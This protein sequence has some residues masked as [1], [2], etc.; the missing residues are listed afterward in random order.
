MLEEIIESVG[1]SGK[2]QWMTVMLI[3]SCKSVMSLSMLMMAY[4]GLVPDWWCY[5][6]DEKS[7]SVAP[8]NSS[9]HYYQVCNETSVC[10]RN[11]EADTKTVVSKFDLVC[12]NTWIKPTVTAVQMG[13]VLVGALIGGQSGDVFGRKKTIYTAIL[14]HS[15]FNII[16]AFSVNWQMFAAFRFLI[17]GCIGTFLVSVVYPLEFIGRKHRAVVSAIPFWT[18]GLILLALASYLIRDWKILHIGL[19]VVSSPYLLGWFVVPESLRWLSTKDRIE[20]AKEILDKIARFNGTKVPENAEDVLRKVAEME[21]KKNRT[22][23][24]YTYLDIYKGFPMLKKSLCIQLIWFSCST[25]S[26]GLSFGIST[27]SGNFYLNFF[28]MSVTELTTYFPTIYCLE[29]IGRRY[30]CAG[31]LFLAAASCITALIIQAVND[32]SK[33][34][35]ITGVSLLAKI[36][37]GS[38]WASLVVLSN[39]SYPTV[40]RSLG[41]G[42]ANTMAR[43]GGILAPFIF[44]LGSNRMIPYIIMAVLLV[45][46]G[47]CA[48]LQKETRGLALEDLIETVAEENERKDRKKSSIYNISS[49]SNGT[50]SQVGEQINSLS[51]NTNT[52]SI[53]EISTQM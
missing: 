46:S 2:F 26:Y 27:F 18:T 31:A 53:N 11:Y 32:V 48:L 30:T 38:A 8:L 4:G 28:L 5:P 9:S 22:E 42:A 39:E 29:K 6:E 23:K 36:L 47:I 51:Q 34:S 1:S 3:M 10:S 49:E 24:K 40:I 45:S 7:V 14:L 52:K 50:I 16:V 15:I 13:G 41:Y 19:G 35:M 21:K 43:I 37:T 12:E 20:E 44:S 25:T 33:S 17:G